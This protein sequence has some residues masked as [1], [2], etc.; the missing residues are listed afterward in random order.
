MAAW[1]GSVNV[2][3]WYQVGYEEPFEIVAIDIDAETVDIQGFDG[4]IEEIDFET[5][6]QLGAR[7]VAAPEDWTGAMDM[8]RNFAFD[9]MPDGMRGNP[10]D[11]IELYL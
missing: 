1:L 3:D 10:L 8:D 2:G 5:W 7:P 11:Q 9:Q 6:S 4:T